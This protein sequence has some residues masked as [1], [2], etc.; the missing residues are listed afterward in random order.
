MSV[1]M[2]QLGRSQRRPTM[3]AY[4]HIAPALVRDAAERLDQ[5]LGGDDLRN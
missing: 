4:A 3:N 2:E 1:M 5:I